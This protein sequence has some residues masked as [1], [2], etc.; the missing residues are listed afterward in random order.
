M[1]PLSSVE[2]MLQPGACAPRGGLLSVP[3][4]GW[5]PEF[6]LGGSNKMLKRCSKGIRLS[7]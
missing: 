5:T 2:K 3:E 1:D 7:W 4:L 6:L